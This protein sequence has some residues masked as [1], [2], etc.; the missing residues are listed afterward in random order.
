M[1][2]VIIVI[3]NPSSPGIDKLSIANKVHVTIAEKEI[4]PLAVSRG[5]HLSWLQSN[6]HKIPSV[7]QR[8]AGLPRS[9]S[10]IRDGKHVARDL[11]SGYANGQRAKS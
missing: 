2:L 4:R 11:D 9:N 8:G 3:L 10:R 5:L 7:I 6:D 1:R